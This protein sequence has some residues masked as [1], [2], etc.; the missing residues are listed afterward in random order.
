LKRRD[1]R[2]PTCALLCGSATIAGAIFAVTVFLAGR[3][4]DGALDAS[5]ALASL[6]GAAAVSGVAVPSLMRKVTPVA[7]QT[8]GLAVECAGSLALAAVSSR[9]QLPLL[10]LGDALVGV[11]FVAA[12]VA[13]TITITAEVGDHEQGALSGLLNVS[14]ELGGGIGIAVVVMV[15]NLSDTGDGA[16]LLSNLRPS[17][18][19]AATIAA[20]GAFAAR[21]ARHRRPGAKP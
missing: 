5:L 12:L 11:G 21:S 7:V 4:E 13:T 2:Q 16:T 6:G 8:L 1:V 17:A 19:A 10:V 20:A 9:S 3:T 18:L 15:A 14:L